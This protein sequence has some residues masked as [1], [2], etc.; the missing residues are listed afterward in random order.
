MGHEVILKGC[1]NRQPN[2]DASPAHPALA[3]ACDA[4]RSSETPPRFTMQ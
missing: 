2:R 3:Y 4:W 1:Y